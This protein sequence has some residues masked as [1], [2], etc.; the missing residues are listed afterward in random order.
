[1]TRDS[2]VQHVQAALGLSPAEVHSAIA[3][4]GEAGAVHQVGEGGQIMLETAW[5]QLSGAAG[6][7]LGE[8][9]RRWPLR[10]GAPRDELRNAIAPGWP[11]RRFAAF[12]N[13]LSA[14][15]AAV[16]EGDR[17]SAAGHE[18][19][20]VGHLRQIL[21]WVEEQYRTAGPA[22]PSPEELAAKAPVPDAPRR[23][24]PA[25]EAGPDS[26]FY[27]AFEYLVETGTLVKIDEGIYFHRDE[28]A[29]I[30][31]SLLLYLREKGAVTVSDFRQLLCTSRKY[32]VPLL[33]YF[34]RQRLTRRQGDLRL[35][36]PAAGRGP[37]PG[38]G[39]GVSRGEGEQA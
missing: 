23:A 25:P 7:W 1:M 6:E 29:G 32:A 5:Q 24:A 4:L 33:E 21:D 31:E 15:G 3:S 11:A 37:G 17:V 13:S 20:P 18:P 14:A 26:P 36:G 10:R 35:P 9:H 12:L 30:G 22:P 38:P 28:L 39:P 8:Y 27:Q 16:V 2:A 34:D 19:R